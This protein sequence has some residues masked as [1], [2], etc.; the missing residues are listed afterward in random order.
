M[1]RS[2]P[3]R[4]DHERTHPVRTRLAILAAL[5]LAALLAPDSA[6]RPA[7]AAQALAL[8]EAAL[9]ADAAEEDRLWPSWATPRLGAWPAS[10]MARPPLAPRPA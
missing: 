5:T 9:P 10:T 8:L 2:Y 6:H 7:G 3:D 1:A 4:R